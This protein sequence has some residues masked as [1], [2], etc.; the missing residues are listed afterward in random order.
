M[1]NVKTFFRMYRQLHEILS[2]KE[3]KKTILIALF[4]VISA[5]AE[6]LGVG[7]ILP[8]ILAMLQPKTLLEYDKIAKLFKLL[9]VAPLIF[10]KL[11]LPGLLTLG[12]GI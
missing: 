9:H 2:K 11:P 12:I 4:S 10:I 3:Q 6:T 7:V 5:L 1:Q 8:F